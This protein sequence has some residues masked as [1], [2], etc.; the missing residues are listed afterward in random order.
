MAAFLVLR[1]INGMMQCLINLPDRERRQEGRGGRDRNKERRTREDLEG[2]AGNLY[3]INN[4]FVVLIKSQV[5]T[6]KKL[7]KFTKE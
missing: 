3:K 6:L 1:K 5:C 7:E 2:R 4:S